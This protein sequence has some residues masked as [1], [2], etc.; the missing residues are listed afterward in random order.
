MLALTLLVRYQDDTPTPSLR[1]TTTPSPFLP[2]DIYIKYPVETLGPFLCDPVFF[3]TT[4][5]QQLP[6]CSIVCEI[7]EACCSE[8]VRAETGPVRSA[9]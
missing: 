5:A 1:Q 6:L 8:S 2:P 4:K 7:G 3:P 9:P